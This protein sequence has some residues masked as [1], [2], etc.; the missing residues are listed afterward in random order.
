MRSNNFQGFR[1]QSC[2]VLCPFLNSYRYRQAV[3]IGWYLVKAH[4]LTG[5]IF[6]LLQEGYVT[7]ESPF[8]HKGN[9][10]DNGDK[11]GIGCAYAT[12]TVTVKLLQR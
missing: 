6:F 5:I 8:H 3:F 7:V 1:N 9:F 11:I 4:T 10:D 12:S 2:T